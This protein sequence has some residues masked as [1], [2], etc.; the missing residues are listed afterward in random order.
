M[1]T[2]YGI[3]PDHRRIG[4]AVWRRRRVLGSQSRLLVIER[5]PSWR[6]CENELGFK[7]LK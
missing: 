5:A 7:M 2:S 4:A 1:E 6:R 3:N